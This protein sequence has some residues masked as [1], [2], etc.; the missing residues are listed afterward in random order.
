MHSLPI[1]V[2]SSVDTV[3]AAGCV[4]VRPVPIT[5]AAS[6]LL[7]VPTPGAVPVAPNGGAAQGYAG[8]QLSRERRRI[9]R[10]VAV[11]NRQLG[12]PHLIGR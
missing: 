6:A 10:H 2:L 3:D 12:D 4:L 8:Q 1:M 11:L 5:R 9:D 7:T